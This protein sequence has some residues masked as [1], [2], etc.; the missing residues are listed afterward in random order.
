MVYTLYTCVFRFI[1][2]RSA[3]Q[4]VLRYRGK[5]LPFILF[6]LQFGYVFLFFPFFVI[7]I[8]FCFIHLAFYSMPYMHS[9]HPFLMAFVVHTVLI[10]PPMKELKNAIPSIPFRLCVSVRFLHSFFRNLWEVT[11]ANRLKSY[12]FS[13]A[14]F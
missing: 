5:R 12:R 7:S 11:I 8:P 14:T 4:K 10:Y 2:E 6:A 9:F 1:S 3:I 13:H